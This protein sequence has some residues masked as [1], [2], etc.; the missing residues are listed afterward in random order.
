[1]KCATAR[2]MIHLGRDG[3]FTERESR[4][5]A[6]HLVCCEECAAL[7]RD[8]QRMAERIARVRGSVPELSQP[9]HLVQSV[10]GAIR[11]RRRPEEREQPGDLDWLLSPGVRFAASL[12]AIV[13]VLVFAVQGGG[14]VAAVSGLE[15]K[16]A[17]PTGSAKGAAAYCVNTLAIE[18]D[19][20]I[21]PVVNSIVAKY[22]LVVDGNVIIAR[23]LLEEVNVAGPVGPF[24]IARLDIE[25]HGAH[26]QV[27]R[28]H[29]AR[30]TVLTDDNSLEPGQRS[31]FDACA[32]TGLEIR[33]WLCGHSRQAFA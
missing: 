7:Q 28:K 16:M 22:G 21:R 20:V 26:D 9:E 33:N 4:E 23:N 13:V 6:D 31:R 29:K 1:M 3:E 10:L 8:V 5:L 2:K 32:T 14:T 15:A 30:L 25:G 17:L 18:R 27:Y 12:A 19:P 11:V 24:E